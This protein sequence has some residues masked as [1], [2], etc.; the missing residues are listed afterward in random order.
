M[1]LIYTFND[2]FAFIAETT[3]RGIKYLHEHF[4]HYLSSESSSTI[5]REPTDKEEIANIISTLNFTRLLSQ[6]YNL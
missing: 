1:L 2:Y 3:K 4:S 5:F 6:I